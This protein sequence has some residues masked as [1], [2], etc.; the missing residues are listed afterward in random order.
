MEPWIRVSVVQQVSTSL[1]RSAANLHTTDGS[2]C[3]VGVATTLRTGRS[4]HRMP[5]EARNLSVLQNV[6]TDSVTD[7]AFCSMGFFF[8]SWVKRP[9]R[10]IQPSP[11]SSAEV[12]N[13]WSYTSAPPIRSSGAGNGR[14]Y[15]YM[16]K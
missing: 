13:E 2:D 10:E 16:R 15:L 3:A 8:F 6:Q 12:N 4:G 14:L 5:V 1:R 7:A 9:Q 11:L